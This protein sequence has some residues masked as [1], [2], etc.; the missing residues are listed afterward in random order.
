MTEEENILFTIGFAL[1]KT[2]LRPRS[3]DRFAN[4]LA[5]K[6]AARIIYD[7]MKLCGFKITPG[8]GI[9]GHSTHGT[10][11][12]SNEPDEGA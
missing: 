4:D 11:R 5:T 6:A 3:K 1:S 8:P 9:E 7:H 10:G 2:S 12:T